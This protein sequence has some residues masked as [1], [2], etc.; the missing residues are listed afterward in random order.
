[1]TKQDKDEIR[2]MLGDV[3]AAHNEKIDGKFNLINEKL[4]RIEA[5]TTKTNGRVNKLE[6][7][8]EQLKINDIEH[9]INCPLVSRV[10]TIEETEQFKKGELRMITILSTV[11]ASIAAIII[12]IA[13]IYFNN[14]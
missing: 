14:K 5:Q 3:L 12:S 11:T 9:I 1:M 2:E 4:E 13:A 8:T 10:K 7:K 6:D